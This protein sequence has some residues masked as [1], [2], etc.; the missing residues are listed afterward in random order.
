VDA[1]LC[2]GC[3]PCVEICPQVFRLED[4][5][6]AVRTESVSPEDQPDCLA[7]MLQ[8]PTGAIVVET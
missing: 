7:A 8:C 3:G 6:A 5:C 2:E 1:E 4:D